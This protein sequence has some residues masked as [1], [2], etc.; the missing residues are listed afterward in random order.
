[1][2]RRLG[3]RDIDVEE[4]CVSVS[5]ITHR[6][7]F[8]KEERD[9]LHEKVQILY[10]EYVVSKW[11]EEKL[12]EGVAETLRAVALE[13]PQKT[14]QRMQTREEWASNHGLRLDGKR[15]P[16]PPKAKKKT[17]FDIAPGDR[18]TAAGPSEPIDPQVFEEQWM[19]AQIAKRKEEDRFIKG[20]RLRKIA[21]PPPR[22]AEPKNFWI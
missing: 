20:R 10:D 18:G 22:R 13:S 2:E 9:E 3:R 14:E 16:G 11:E 15:K 5:A 1:M 8:T 4:L 19:D 21:D 7:K 17:V 12:D 6:N